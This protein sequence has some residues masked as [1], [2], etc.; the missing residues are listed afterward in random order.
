MSTSHVSLLPSDPDDKTQISLRNGLQNDHYQKINHG[1]NSE[2]AG[3]LSPGKH[4]EVTKIELFYDLFFVANLTVFTYIHSVSDG[5][6]LLQYIWFFCILW[7]SWYQVALF[8][9][10]Y[11]QYDC[12][13]HR[14]AKVVQFGVMIMYAAVGPMFKLGES[15]YTKQN[16]YDRN[17]NSAN[18]YY[19]V[20]TLS[21]MTSRLVLALQYYIIRRESKYSNPS[22][23]KPLAVLITVYTLAATVYFIAYFFFTKSGNSLAWISWFVV[24]PL[25]SIIAT[26]VACTSHEVN[27]KILSHLP[28]LKKLI[29]A[30][31]L[32]ESDKFSFSNKLLVERLSLLTLII[33]GEG[34]ISIAKQCQIIADL[35]TFSWS[36]TNVIDIFCSV[37]IV[38]C[39]YLLY[40]DWMEG[41]AMR[42]M[43][44]LRQRIWASL[45]FPFHLFLVLAIQGIKLSILWS[46]A[47]ENIKKIDR[48][49]EGWI[50]QP[51]MTPAILNETQFQEVWHDWNST[52][53][54]TIE[55]QS[56]AVKTYPDAL[57]AMNDDGRISG[58]LNYL[59]GKNLSGDPIEVT[60]EDAICAYRLLNYTAKTSIYTLA[61]FSSPG[62]QDEETESLFVANFTLTDKYWHDKVDAGGIGDTKF[63]KATQDHFKL[64][65][66]QRKEMTPLPEDVGSQH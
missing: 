1:R 13:I 16:E 60:I 54:T 33:L 2:A 61:G 30:L 37:L 10:R 25:E 40:F 41:P 38:Y 35:W 44:H 17:L 52:L 34:A 36:A 14:L 23:R 55:D 21:L 20:F 24:A 7:F 39:L 58:A 65:Y 31:I 50:W 15:Q 62:L 9:V 51:D 56:Y 43:G 42:E 27:P 26:C 5:K 18:S 32:G 48:L 3:S 53:R 28:Y 63:L 47:T 64:T 66:R 46:A 59:Q 19:G 8:D 12:L 49:D 6:S 11:S 4:E 22:A 57:D 29:N 45:H